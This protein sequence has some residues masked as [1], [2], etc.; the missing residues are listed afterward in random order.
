MRKSNKYVKN[1]KYDTKK[2]LF[3]LL[4]TLDLLF[5]YLEKL[6]FQLNDQNYPFLC[7]KFTVNNCKES[8]FT[9]HNSKKNAMSLRFKL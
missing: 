6:E 5:S 3:T 9:K 2:R 7:K 1:L 4:M 8:I